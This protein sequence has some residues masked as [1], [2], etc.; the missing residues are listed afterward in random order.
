[1][2]LIARMPRTDNGG[3]LTTD[4]FEGEWE[5]KQLR[6]PAGQLQPMSRIKTQLGRPG[7]LFEFPA[8]SCQVCPM[9][10]QCASPNNKSGAHSLFVIK[11]DE[12]LIRAHLVRRAEPDF[13]RCWPSVPRWNG[14]RRG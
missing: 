13:G 7:L 6:C 4:P 5:R 3:R 8:A 1:M 12:Q 11:E 10:K 9:Q 2:E 14:C